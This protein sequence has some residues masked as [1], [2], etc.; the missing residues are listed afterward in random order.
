MNQ[1]KIVIPG[2]LRISKIVA[3]IM[4]AWVL[5]GVISLTLRT[6][7]LAFSAN[8][9]T[10]FV[11]FV[12]NT[13]AD[14]LNPFRGIFP[15]KTVGETG[16]FDVAA[17]F[18]IIIYLFVMWGFSALIHYLQNKIDISRKEQERALNQKVMLANSRPRTSSRSK[19]TS[20]K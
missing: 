8:P 4:Y 5:I 15:A 3:Y 19:K 2:Y 9:S 20:R 17:M 16:Y 18:A 6:F 7:L 10:P 14:Y 11:K 12:Y 13:S 1:E